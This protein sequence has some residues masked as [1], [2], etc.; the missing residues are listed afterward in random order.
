MNS[1]I[2]ILKAVYKQVL[3]GVRRSGPSI[4]DFEIFGDPFSIDGSMICNTG[5]NLTFMPT[6]VFGPHDSS[7]PISLRNIG[8][9]EKAICLCYS[10]DA[11][12]ISL[13][14]VTLIKY[15]TV[16]FRYTGLHY[17]GFEVDLL[18]LRE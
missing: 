17:T 3:T 1:Y 10:F 11:M 15:S 12:T 9:D 6:V 5:V 4:S 14:W 8:V 18:K 7:R 13:G 16:D 2:T